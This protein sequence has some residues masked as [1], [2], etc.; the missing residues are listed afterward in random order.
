[1]QRPGKFRR[2]GL[3]KG[4]H[5][6]A[7]VSRSQKLD[8]RFVLNT[9]YE[10]AT[11]QYLCASVKSGLLPSRYRVMITYGWISNHFYANDPSS[12][13]FGAID[14]SVDDLRLAAT[15]IIG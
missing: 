3:R 4:R 15:G 7:V 13:K 14:C 12:N 1:M 2:A 6:L 11:Q 5:R 10:Q 9:M 8:I